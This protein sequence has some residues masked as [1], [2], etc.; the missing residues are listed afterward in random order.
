MKWKESLQVLLALFASAIFCAVCVNLILYADLGSDS[1]TVFEDGLHESLHI[2]VGMAS[3]FYN[4]AV[5]LIGLLL[6]RKN[7]GW[8]TFAFALMEGKAIDLLNEWMFPF[9]GNPSSLF[10]KWIY[11]FAAIFCLAVSIALLVLYR[12]GMDG[13]DAIC[14]GLE[15]RLHLSYK[16]LRTAGDALL[17]VFGFLMGGRVGPGCIPAVFLTGITAHFMVRGLKRI[18]LGLPEEAV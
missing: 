15:E 12:K 3:Y 4:G 14:Y 16:W 5:I 7:I 17:L 1:I 9:F 10:M 11:V 18:G 8:T 13:L 6:A 2:S